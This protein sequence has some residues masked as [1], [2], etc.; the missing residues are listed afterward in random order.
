MRVLIVGAM[1]EYAIE[2]FY[3]KYLRQMDIDVEVFA[4]QDRF[5][6]YYNRKLFNKILF[7]VG[8]KRI[9]KE[10]N[11]EL[12]G[13]VEDLKPDVLFVFKGMEVYPATLA[14]IRR[15]NIRLINYNPDSPFIFSGRGSGNSNVSNSI[16]LFD[17]HLT[18]DATIRDGIINKF[19][20]RTELLPFGFDLS[21]DTFKSCATENEVSK[22]CF[23]GTPDKYRAEFLT[24]LAKEN[25]PIDV[26]GKNWEG[27]VNHLNITIHPPV[28]GLT[29]WKTLRRY[30]IQLNLMRPHNPESHN[31]RTFE[32]PGV[33]GIL[34]A[35][36]TEDHKFY[37]EPGKEIFLYSNLETCVDQ[38][39]NLLA[40]TPSEANAI[41][42]N[43]R[44]RSIESRYSYKDRSHYL[45]E[46]L[47]DLLNEKK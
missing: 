38:I 4:A 20:I 46:I 47:K 9:Y 29:L 39:K 28:Y 14:K 42:E 33:G 36:E 41:R 22:L 26:Y 5:L 21:P 13:A 18:Y 25:V 3:L 24:E 35:P 7:R 23:L 12:L 30:R 44:K 45:I 17:L 8:Y 37:F 19:G 6:K 16:S 43:A 32:V 11:K 2:R 15:K 10:I 1:S 31:M 34:L 40:F 27:F